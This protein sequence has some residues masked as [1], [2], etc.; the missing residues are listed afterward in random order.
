MPNSSQIFLDKVNCIATGESGKHGDDLY[1]IYKA[2]GGLDQ[3]HPDKGTGRPDIKAGESWDV[4]I[5]IDFNAT[6]DVK[7]YDKDNTSSNEYLGHY[8]FD[9][10][11]Q[12]KNLTVDLN[13]QERDGKYQYV[14]TPTA[15]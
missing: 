6:V 3:R 8:V 15:S 7:L 14:L 4:G 1:L 2:D 10:N 5:Y 11:D 13:N 12:D 9:V